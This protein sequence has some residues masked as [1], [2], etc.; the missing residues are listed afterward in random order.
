MASTSAATDRLTAGVPPPQLNV[1]EPVADNYF[2]VNAVIMM[3]DT[4]AAF[5]VAPDRS[6]GGS[7]LA[8]GSL[9]LMVHRRCLFDDGRGVGEP[10]NETQGI[11]SYAAGPV[12]RIG[13]GLVVRGVHRIRLDASA[14]A[15]A[16]FRPL[17]DDVFANPVVAF[18]ALGSTSP[19]DWAKA[20]RTTYSAV[21]TALPANVA[22]MTLMP[23][24]DGVLLR[25]SH[26]FAV[27]EDP[28]LSAPAT[29][30]LAAL[31]PA[32]GADNVTEL[33]LTGNQPLADVQRMQWKT[34]DMGEAGVMP[35]TPPRLNR[36]VQ[37]PDMD[38]TLDAMQ[39]RTFLLTK[40]DAP[41]EARSSFL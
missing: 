13:H 8:D 17:M 34:D 27:G 1:T 33:S 30:S 40:A 12:H 19:G 9:E 37:L 25:L 5:S 36:D 31:L 21:G 35:P 29:V 2:P 11:T 10:L 41:R 28:T 22:L 7:S 6:E 24:P 20:H 4:T 32:L 38:V 18:S 39:I 16:G 14:G 26:Q 3:N 15:A 23:R